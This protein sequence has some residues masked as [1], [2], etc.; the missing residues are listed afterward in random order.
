MSIEIGSAVDLPVIR[1]LFRQG[2][3]GAK[4]FGDED[5]AAMT[6][7]IGRDGDGE[8]W[9]AL[10]VQIEPRPETLPSQLPDRLYVR[11]V[12]IGRRG[13]PSRDGALLLSAATRLLHRPD[14]ARQ[15]ILHTDQ[16]WLQAAAADSGFAEVDRV[17]FYQRT[18][19]DLPQPSQSVSDA[20]ID[21]RPVG[22][23][24]L[25]GLAQLDAAAFPPLWHMGEGE[26]AALLF[27]SRLIMAHFQGEPVGYAG[28]TLLGEESEESPS[29]T[30]IKKEK[31]PASGFLIRLAVHPAFQGQGIGRYLLIESL[32][33]SHSL[34]VNHVML[35]TQVSN[36]PS[37][38]L[39]AQMGFRPTSQSFSVYVHQI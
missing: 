3:H 23:A 11:G 13:A 17:R 38:K 12:T 37:Q 24:D 29:F 4:Q 16:R 1:H 6:A 2:A 14:G 22:P 27:T 33:Y 15:L 8:T 32:R 28:L 25:Y 5:L 36:Y 7:L 19:T 18:Q 39:Y 9:G 21:L 20:G 26:L 34:G 30:E 10:V 31:A 35:N